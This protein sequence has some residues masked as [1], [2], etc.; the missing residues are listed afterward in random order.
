MKI[1]SKNPT[2]YLKLAEH[3][4]VEPLVFDFESGLICD[5]YY[6]RTRFNATTSLLLCGKF[7][8]NNLN[9][10]RYLLNNPCNG[11]YIFIGTIELPQIY[12]TILAHEFVHS[13]QKKNGTMLRET[14]TIRELEADV[15][16]TD[17]LIKNNIDAVE[18]LRQLKSQVDSKTSFKTIFAELTPL[19]RLS[20]FTFFIVVIFDFIMGHL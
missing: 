3:F 12:D 9:I 15:L 14:H 8:K 7:T 18:G 4:K 1:C 2:L 19:F 10:I 11:G 20:I 6:C 17:F 5:G 13:L 16:S